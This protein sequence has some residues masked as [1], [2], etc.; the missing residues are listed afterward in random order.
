MAA[1]FTGRQHAHE[2]SVGTFAVDYN[3]PLLE[4]FG[5]R[6]DDDGRRLGWA[7]GQSGA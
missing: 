7:R 3:H 6:E 1:R 5:V 4:R 2:D